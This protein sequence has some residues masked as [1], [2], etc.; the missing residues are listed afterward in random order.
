MNRSLCSCSVGVVVLVPRD[1]AGSEL[2]GDVAKAPDP[3]DREGTVL[4]AGPLPGRWAR[5]EAEDQAR[6]VREVTDLPTAAGAERQE[7]PA[8]ARLAD[9]VR[10]MVLAAEQAFGEQL[11]LVLGAERLDVAQGHFG[12]TA[13]PVLREGNLDVRLRR[14]PER[15]ATR[16]FNRLNHPTARAPVDRAERHVLQP[17][18]AKR[19]GVVLPFDRERRQLAR[20]SV[21]RNT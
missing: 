4:L 19:S 8:V 21:T 5:L 14:V 11:T 15:S 10:S 2:P 12:E 20:G 18:G 17:V 13:P 1:L 16:H 3:I 9:E 7:H 6:S